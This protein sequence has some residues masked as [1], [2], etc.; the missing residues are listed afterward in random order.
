MEQKTL[1]QNIK[2]K[3]RK[4]SLRRW[5]SVFL[6][7]VVAAVGY[8]YFF[9]QEEVQPKPIIKYGVVDTGD[10]IRSI[11][12][13]GTLQAT[14]T[15][16]V[17][18]QV[19]GTIRALYCDFNSHVKAGMV[20][21]QL[22]PTFY[23][24]AVKEA[25][26]NYE[27]AKSELENAKTEVNRANELVK[28]DL[29]SKAEY[30]VAT[31]KV[32]S[33]TASL[34]QTKAALDRSKVNLGYT[35]IRSPISGTVV[36][37]N[38]DVGQTVAA[39]LNAPVLFTIAEDLQKM[40]VQVNVDEA[41]VGQVKT[42]QEATFTV[43]AFPG[44]TFKGNVSMVRISPTTLQNVVTYTVVV[45]APNDSL[46]LLPG[47]TATTTIIS[48]ARSNV[49]RVP[50]AALRF[51]PPVTD[52]SKHNGRPGG[53]NGNRMGG[54]KRG[55]GENFGVIFKKKNL[56]KDS[57]DFPFEPVRVKTGLND[58]NYTEVIIEGASLS[59]GDS[60]AIGSITMGSKAPTATNPLNQQQPGAN[61]AM[62]RM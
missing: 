12:S 27:R 19:S 39:S 55:G 6:L 2:S 22:D 61:R 17:G 34:S 51:K 56:S 60:I 53:M 48:E 26:A 8:R 38:V 14:K 41:D 33:L 32:N 28:K 29:I 31:T 10:V 62:R 47:M 7:L 59:I 1:E 52:T 45:A 18:S 4:K 58:G 57:K 42:G 49:L 3:K 25:E 40:E 37:R 20:V 5:I 50:T 21:A 23:Q 16:Q 46:K 11:S 15:V 13:T 24:A 30:E 9:M 43:D 54:G 36:S 44:E 35:T